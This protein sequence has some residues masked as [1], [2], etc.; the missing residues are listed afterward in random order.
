MPVLQITG[1][2]DTSLTALD[3][4]LITAIHRG[5]V[6]PLYAD[7]LARVRRCLGCDIAPATVL[8]EGGAPGADAEARR[9]AQRSGLPVL[10]FPADWNAHGKAAGPLR[11]SAMLA[12][13]HPDLGEVEKPAWVLA[14]PGGVGTADMVAKAHRAGLP[15]LDLGGAHRSEFAPFQRWTKDDAWL[16]RVGHPETIAKARRERPGVGLPIASGHWLKV[17]GEVCLSGS[18]E[19]VGRDAHG[20][21][22]HPLFANPFPVK[23]LGKDKPDMVAVCVA[24]AWTEMHIDEALQPFERHLHELARRPDVRAALAQLYTAG[25]VLVCWCDSRKPCHACVVARA[26]LLT[27]AAVANRQVWSQPVGSRHGEHAPALQ[28]QQADQPLLPHGH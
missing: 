19:Y 1:G 2:R 14:F 3:A 9:I 16:L 22:G 17:R 8:Y 4:A 28:G 13:Q 12:G 20:L 24:G 26:A 23:P 18:C 27:A 15:V 11:N 6:C 21:R 25:K 7:L 10:T 5:P